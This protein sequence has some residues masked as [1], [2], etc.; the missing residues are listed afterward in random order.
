MKRQAV[1]VLHVVDGIAVSLAASAHPPATVAAIRPDTK[2][3]GATADRTRTG[4]LGARY[5]AQ[6]NAV[7]LYE[8]EDIHGSSSNF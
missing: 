3:I 8:F 7:V 6:F 1:S 4:I 2:P 5:M